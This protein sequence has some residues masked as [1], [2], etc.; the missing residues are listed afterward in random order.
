MSRPLSVNR[1]R[2]I[3]WLQDLLPVWEVPVTAS[4]LHRGHPEITRPVYASALKQLTATGVLQVTPGE[5]DQTFYF[6]PTK[7]KVCDLQTLIC[8]GRLDHE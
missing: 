3:G 8:K 5:R 1:A 7:R 2:V 6:P 4:M